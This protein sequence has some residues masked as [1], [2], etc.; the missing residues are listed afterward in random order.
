MDIL[1][2]PLTD[3]TMGAYTTNQIARYMYLTP[4]GALYH[5]HNL[6]QKDLIRVPYRHHWAVKEEDQFEELKDTLQKMSASFKIKPK[7]DDLIW[8]VITKRI[9]DEP[10]RRDEEGNVTSLPTTKEQRVLVAAD[11]LLQA[12]PEHLHEG[13]R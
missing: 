10:E 6:W 4:G 7:G 12:I 1:R 9:K 3:G 2:R 5:I 13:K 8:T 11:S